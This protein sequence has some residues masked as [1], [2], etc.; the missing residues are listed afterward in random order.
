MARELPVVLMQV[1]SRDPAIGV[2]DLAEEVAGVLADHP[3]TQLLAYP[4]YN[5]CSVQGDPDARRRAYE[6]LA[7][8]IDGP[9][10]TSLRAVARAS[11]VWLMPGTV[12]ERG[13]DGGLYNTAVVIAPNGEVVASYRKIFPWRPFE[14]FKPG[15]RF[16]VFDMPG[17]GRVGL[18]ICYDIW[19]PEVARQLAWMGA[20][21]LIY[22]AQT[23]TC[24]RA[25]EL[26][27]AQATAIANQVFVISLNAAAPAGTGRSIVVDPE[28]LVRMQ[29]PSEVATTLT[30]VLSLDEVT[31]V[32]A[33]GTCGLNRLWAQVRP[34]D[35]AL[36]LPAYEGSMRRFATSEGHPSAPALTDRKR[37]R[38]RD[39]QEG[40]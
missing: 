37:N 20:E 38:L 2:A 30:D 14:P 6:E 15:N 35:P 39:R 10:I 5:V 11:G 1:P 16:V 27:L 34:D 32:R 33:H 9:R 22:P 40:A 13:E 18:G 29:A 36:E 25:Q 4:E 23:S 24:D 26:V 31:R 21:L 28:G 19:F 8:P 12:P 3:A 17:V 7:E